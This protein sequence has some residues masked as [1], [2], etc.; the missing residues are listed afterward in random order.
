MALRGYSAVSDY[1]AQA[2]GNTVNTGTV[3]LD[4]SQYTPRTSLPSHGLPVWMLLAFIAGLLMNFMPCVLPVMSIKVLSL[5]QQAGESRRRALA[6]GVA[7]AAGMMAVFLALA[8]VAI[9]FGLGW[10]E[11]FQSQTFLIAMIAIVFA[12]ALS[13]F[14][15]YEFRVPRVGALAT[16]ATREGLGSAFL[17]GMLASLLATPCSG[18]FLGSTLAWTLTQPPVIVLLIFAHAGI[19][20]GLTLC[21]FQRTPPC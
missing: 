6:M 3:G 8:L 14:G 20:D 13:L 18:P 21:V 7:F 12:F 11:Q 2:S 16:H 4:F 15:V 17:K 9:L 5:V 19:R 1:R 10:G